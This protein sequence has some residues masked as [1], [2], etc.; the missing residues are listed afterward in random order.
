MDFLVYHWHCIL[1]VIGIIGY[2][3]FVTV[4]KVNEMDDV[5]ES[6]FYINNNHIKS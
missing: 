3:I 4:T 6:D 1:P 5:S 2:L